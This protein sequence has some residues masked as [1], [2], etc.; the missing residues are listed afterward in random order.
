MVE[1]LSNTCKV[2]LDVWQCQTYQKS[3]IFSSKAAQ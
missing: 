3:I 1:E 2:N